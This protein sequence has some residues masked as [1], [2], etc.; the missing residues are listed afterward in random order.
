V[1]AVQFWL[2]GQLRRSTYKKSE[3][4]QHRVL[5]AAVRAIADKG[6]AATSVQDIASAAGMSKGAVHYHFENKDELLERVLDRCVD[7]IEARVRG[8]FEE[9][10]TP[11]DRVRRAVLEMWRLRRDDAP[12]FRVLAELQVVARQNERIRKAF[13]AAYKRSR[14]QIVEVGFKKLIELGLR[15]KVSLT[16]VPRLLLAALDGLALQHFID[17]VAPEEEAEMLRALETIAMA[18]FEL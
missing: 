6:L 14:E 10:G 12:E 7:V 16:V 8:A 11:M 9:P 18:T 5:D 17:P 1:S 13:S 3:D 2:S 4:S 15:P